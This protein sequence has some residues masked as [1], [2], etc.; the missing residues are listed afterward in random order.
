MT[1]QRPQKGKQNTQHK[2]GKSYGTLPTV[3]I[4]GKQTHKSGAEDIPAKVI[5]DKSGVIRGR[6][7]E[8]KIMPVGKAAPKIIKILWSNR[9]VGGICNHCKGGG[10]G[11]EIV[12]FLILIKKW[13]DK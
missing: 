5:V 2:G 13:R 12:D 4:T 1:A 3:R 8:K 7:E 6:K 10:K 11:T 9:P